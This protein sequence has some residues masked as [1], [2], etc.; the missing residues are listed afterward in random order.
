MANKIHISEM[1]WIN[2]EDEA[3]PV[4]QTVLFL[5]R[6]NPWDGEYTDAI[7]FQGI[8]RYT[9]RCGISIPEILTSLSVEFN[10]YDRGKVTHWMPCPKLP[11]K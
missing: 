2:I 11:Q 3:P 10:S 6:H 9:I 5:L 8:Y 1:S 7:I 4:G